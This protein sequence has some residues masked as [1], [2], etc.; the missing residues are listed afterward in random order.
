MGDAR[1]AI[2][3]GEEDFGL[4]PL[5]AAATGRPAIALRRGGALE[6]VVD[7]VTGTFFDDPT[8]ESLAEVLRSFD[9][10]RY[11]PQMLRAHAE[12]F[13]P[14]TFSQKL[15]TIVERVRASGR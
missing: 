10:T 4:L 15:R 12:R 8:P 5:E 1:A 6:T 9:A 11:D 7:G 13:A 14:Q 3:P 2:L